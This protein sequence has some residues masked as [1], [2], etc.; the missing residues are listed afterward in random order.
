MANRIR[1]VPAP[2]L[3]KKEGPN[4]GNLVWVKCREFSCLAFLDS[5]GNWINFYDGKKVHDFVKVVGK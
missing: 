1:F 3:K 5:K 4:H 2:D